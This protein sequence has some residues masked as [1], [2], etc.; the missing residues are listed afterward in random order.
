[1]TI[2][3]LLI[4]L[5]ILSLV[6]LLRFARGRAS[7][8]IKSEELD[9]RTRPVDLEAFRNLV[10]PDEERFLRSRLSGSDFR[11]VQRE[12]LRAA[13]EYISGAAENAAVLLR[14]GEAAAAHPDPNIAAAGAQL[15]DNALRL[16]LYALFA[17]SKLY[18]RI[19][20]PGANLSPGSL[21]DQ[22]QNLSGIAGRLAVLQNPVRVSR[23]T[24]SL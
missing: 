16:R 10:D 19:V 24:A 14:L 4:V 20:I 9:G 15:I 17:V 2:P 18:V 5:S 21:A 12:R 3:L 22:Y 1:M 23:V 11:R 6:W 8:I 7:A 13:V